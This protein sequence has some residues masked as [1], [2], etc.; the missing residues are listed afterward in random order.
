MAPSKRGKRQ[1]YVCT[2]CKRRLGDNPDFGY[3]RAPRL[4]TALDL[5]QSSMAA[6]SIRN[7]AP[8]PGVEVHADAAA[9]MPEQHS[10]V[11]E[12]CAKTVKPPCAGAKRGCDGKRRKVRG[13]G[14][15]VVPAMDLAP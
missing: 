4:H 14:S 6:A 3:R 9:R 2:T 13:G 15:H 1:R 7:D 11:V 10:K 5:M 8:A 12:G